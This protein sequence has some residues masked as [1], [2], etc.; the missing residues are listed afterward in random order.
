M[1]AREQQEEWKKRFGTKVYRYTEDEAH[2]LVFATCL[3]E[4]SHAEMQRM[5]EAQADQQSATLFDAVPDVEVFLAIAK[6]ADAKAVIGGS[7]TT[8]GMYEHPRRRLVASDI[9]MVLRHEFTHLMHFGQMERLGQP[10]LIWVQEGIA[11]LYENYDLQPDGAIVFQPNLRHNQAR[12]MASA[13]TFMPFAKL[14][15]LSLDDFMDKSQQ[16]YPQVRSMFEYIAD[17]GKLRKWYRRYTETYAQDRTG[18]LALEEVFGKPLSQIENDWRTW[19]LKRPA[20]SVSAAVGNRNI[21]I[22]VVGATD[23][24]QVRKV[25]RLGIAARAG[26]KVGDVITAVDGT[27]VRS[28]REFIAALGSVKAQNATLTVRRGQERVEIAIEFPAANSGARAGVT[29]SVVPANGHW[30]DIRREFFSPGHIASHS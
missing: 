15:T 17:S 28:A 10:H 25:E 21:G 24:I 26:V 12:K 6:P 1:R 8:E 22:E 5:L 18:K 19:V 7:Q 23:G 2:R 13:R 14:I 20:V 29:D 16:L 30:P 4:A 3:D 27:A 9:G 11:S